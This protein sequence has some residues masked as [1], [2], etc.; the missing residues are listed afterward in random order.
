MRVATL[1]G[2]SIDLGSFGTPAGAASELG[3]AI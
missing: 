2:H 1:I 3:L